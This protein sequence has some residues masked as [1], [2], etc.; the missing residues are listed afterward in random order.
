MRGEPGISIQND[1]L[2]KLMKLQHISQTEM[3][4]LESGD[5]HS[6]RFDS[7]P[8]KRGV[9]WEALFE[10]I[11]LVIIKTAKIASISAAS[12]VVLQLVYAVVLFLL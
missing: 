7:S 5:S 4:S 6:N 2:R 9:D 12:V 1:I 11:K 3:S 8:T 10:K